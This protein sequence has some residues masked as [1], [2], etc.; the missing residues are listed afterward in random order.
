MRDTQLIL[1][2]GVMGSGKS[3]I[4]KLI[5]QRLREQGCKARHVPEGLWDH[6]TSVTLASPHWHAIWNE[7]TPATLILQSQRKWQAF[8]AATL[9]LH[10]VHVFDGQ[11]FHGDLTSLLLINAS[12]PQMTNYIDSLAA[13]SQSLQPRLIYLY[14]AD[15]K[16]GLE[17]TGA[18][19]G[20][21]WVR[22]Q[23]EWKVASPY[24]VGRN[25]TGISGWLQLYHDY[26]Q[27]THDLYARLTLPK[28][29]IETSGG[30]W[31]E[32]QQQICTFLDV[33]YA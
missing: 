20:E 9:P 8:V 13:I 18:L 6:P 16:G 27:L 25:Y 17:R 32:Y 1:V 29:A 11:F 2:E 14:Q 22:R 33:A 19:R 3:T 31:E 15:V 12:R 5:A 21:V 28:L 26:R 24:C 10:T 4:S 23:V 30:A 7:H